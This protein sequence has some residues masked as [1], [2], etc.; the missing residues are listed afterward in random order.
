[1]PSGHGG[2]ALAKPF[3]C[4]G[5]L[6]TLAASV[7]LCAC[8]QSE[9]PPLRLGHSASYGAAGPEAADPRS[10][11]DRAIAYWGQQYAKNPRD[12]DAA[13]S[14]AKNLKAAGQKQAA[15]TVLQQASLY[16]GNDRE[17]ASEYGRLALEFGQVGLAQK[18]L[19]MAHDPANPDW[20][21]VSAHGTV[22]AK[23]GDFKGAIAYYEEALRLAPGQ[24]S[25]INNLAM[26]LAAEGEPQKAEPLLRR[27]ASDP[28][29]DPKVHQNLALVLNLQ[30]KSREAEQ[31]RV[32]AAGPP[33]WRGARRPDVEQERSVPAN[34]GQPSP[35]LRPS[36]P[37]ADA[38]VGDDWSARV[39]VAR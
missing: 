10:E 34:A 14:Y 36:A 24:P 9:A 31:A 13:I 27:A 11:L 2:S 15:L 19:A 23:Q 3:N 8:A 5:L 20:R 26:A 37:P 32:A 28:G 30:G 25:V 7:I 22:L 29:A 18:L 17:L 4:R 38:T 33:D 21:V 35:A 39:A 1:M 12:R 16:H 6:I